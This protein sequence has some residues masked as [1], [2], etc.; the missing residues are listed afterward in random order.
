M[1]RN[2]TIILFACQSFAWFTSK[3][4]VTNRLTAS[5]DYGVSIVESFAPPK[6]WIPGEEV[7]KDVYAVNTGS[8]DAYVKETLTG[9]LNFTYEEKLNAWTSDCLELGPQAVTSI[10]GITTYEGGSYLAWTNAAGV[11]VDAVNSARDN[12]KV[13]NPWHPNTPGVY[14]FRRSIKQGEGDAADTFT[15]AGYYF[16]GSKYYKI[17]LGSDGFRPE[18]GDFEN[19]MMFDIAADQSELQD[20]NGAA[21]TAGKIDAKTGKINSDT[22]KVYY[23]KENKVSD[24]NVIFEHEDA[25]TNHPERLKITY[26][27]VYDAGSYSEQAMKARLETDYNNKQEIADVARDNYDQKKAEYD[28]ATELANARNTLAQ[29]LADVQE[30][31]TNNQTASSDTDTKM[32][33]VN[34]LA[35][36]MLGSDVFNATKITDLAPRTPGKLLTANEIELGNGNTPAL[37][38]G[39]DHIATAQAQANYAELCNLYDEIYGSNGA[40]GLVAEIKGYLNTIKTGTTTTPGNRDNVN[41][42]RNNLKTKMATLVTKVSDF[43]KEYANFTDNEAK[44]TG[45]DLSNGSKTKVDA[46][47]TATTTLNNN[48]NTLDTKV[49]EYVNAYDKYKDSSTGTEATLA[50]KKSAWDTAITT[51]NSTVGSKKTEYEGKLTTITNYHDYDNHTTAHTVTDNAKDFVKDYSADTVDTDGTPA[52]TWNASTDYNTLI[53]SKVAL[54]TEDTFNLPTLS[55]DKAVKDAAATDAKD[56]LDTFNAGSNAVTDIKMYVNLAEDYDNDWK[57]DTRTDKTEAADF[58]LKKVLKAGETSGKLV[59]SVYF[60]ENVNANAYK[61]LTFD[62]NVGLDSIQVTYDANQSGYTTEAVNADPNFKMTASVTGDT[63]SWT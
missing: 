28:Y 14:V 11:D 37:S 21:I 44:V 8:I 6:N 27:A 9:V 16:D 2:W 36:T 40:S 63:V 24:K 5:S 31:Y 43:Q 18:D 58:Y 54:P 19:G 15:Y 51:Y 4:E 50:D 60:D 62:L 56:K 48:T 55:A 17:V 25:D 3:D 38:A 10:D 12:D 41:T 20:G 7:N 1:R 53:L 13:A 30:A 23:V 46:L 42:A 39:S 32:Q 22:L 29:A 52:V 59:D 45:V 35:D 26:N 57:F 49:T 33:A 61:N 47:A 34:S